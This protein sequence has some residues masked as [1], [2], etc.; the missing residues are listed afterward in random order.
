MAEFNVFM[1]VLIA[2][3]LRSFVS[4]EELL[5]NHVVFAM[6]SPPTKYGFE[7]VMSQCRFDEW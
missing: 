3:I 1:G 7:N 5:K 2:F 6:D 4:F